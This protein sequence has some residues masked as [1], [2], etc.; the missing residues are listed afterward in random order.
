LE[1]LAQ[2]SGNDLD[3]LNTKVA[4]ILKR[5]RVNQLLLVTTTTQTITH[6]RYINKGRPTAHSPTT[7]VTEIQFQLQIACQPNAIKEAEKLAGWRLYVTNAPIERLNLTKAIIYY[8]DQWIIERSF[9]RFKRGQL[10]ALPIY[11][12]NQ[13]RIVGLMFCSLWL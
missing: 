9:H 12:Q 8:R 10:P 6:T 2:K 13:D 4:A 11:F 1:L 5:H 7:Q 3:L